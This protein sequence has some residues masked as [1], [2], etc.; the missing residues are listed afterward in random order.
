[1]TTPPRPQPPH[2]LYPAHVD[3]VSAHGDGA[4]MNDAGLALGLGARTDDAGL[5]LARSIGFAGPALHHCTVPHAHVDPAGPR[6][7]PLSLWVTAPWAFHVLSS[8][9]KGDGLRGPRIGVL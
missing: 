4:R 2:L 5:A 7:T 9:E 1:M 6:R 3:T 8:Q